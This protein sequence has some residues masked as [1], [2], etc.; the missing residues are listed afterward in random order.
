MTNEGEG[1]QNK[2]FAFLGKYWGMNLIIFICVLSFIFFS[3]AGS[4]IKEI[5]PGDG[6]NLTRKEIS[7]H[8][9]NPEWS[10]TG[11][12]TSS[13]G[14]ATSNIEA[15]ITGDLYLCGGEERFETKTLLIDYVLCADGSRPK[16]P[17]EED[18][19]SAAGRINPYRNYP[20]DNDAVCPSVTDASGNPISRFAKSIDYKDTGL[21]VSQYDRISFDL[22]KVKK[23][24][25]SCTSIP[26]GISF[27]NT[28]FLNPPRTQKALESQ[29]CSGGKVYLSSSEVVEIDSNSG[30]SFEEYRSED[31]SA[32]GNNI[33]ANR[34][35]SISI[36]GS[37]AD[38]RIDPDPNFLLTNS[39]GVSPPQYHFNCANLTSNKAEFFKYTSKAISAH[40]GFDVSR[41]S[42]MYGYRK[43]VDSNGKDLLDSNGRSQSSETKGSAQL[44]RILF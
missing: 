7:V 18:F 13:F 3:V 16:Y 42:G 31:P 6:F 24:I 33:V 34:N 32:Y 19:L 5:K 26:F 23:T 8:A 37:F 30:D 41:V 21:K 4:Q 25:N 36:A 17:S 40:C 44:R 11:I 14:T 15:K 2:V 22:V 38:L 39:S 1:K 20:W 12:A 10:N 29:V 35:S 43:L 27:D 9:S 28:L